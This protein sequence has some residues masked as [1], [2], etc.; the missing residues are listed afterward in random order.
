M[1]WW[2]EGGIWMYAVLTALVLC[3]GAG[4]VAVLLSIGAFFVPVLKVVSRIAAILVVMGAL[5][6][7]LVGGVGWLSNRS[8][9]EAAVE[10]ADSEMRDVIL[11][12][13]YAEARRP[14]EFGTM[15]TM[16]GLLPGALALVLSVMA[17]GR[18][19]ED[20]E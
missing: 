4:F 17:P 9:V 7:T 10:N 8:L 11:A 12:R 6:P 16:C 20:D 14:I 2:A 1:Y 19:Q 3:L 18:K 15:S 13:G 5:L